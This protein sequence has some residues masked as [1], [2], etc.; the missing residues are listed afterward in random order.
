[1]ALPLDLLRQIQDSNPAAAWEAIV[2]HAWATFCDPVNDANAVSD[3]VKRD[4]GIADVDLFLATARWDLWR[5][6]PAVAKTTANALAEWWEARDGGRAVLI[7][8]GLSLREVPWLLGGLHS[9]GYVVHQAGGTGAELPPNTTPFAKALGFASRSTLY[10]NGAG[11]S[12]RL[13]G[14]RTECL[15]VAWEDAAA[16][17][18]SE[19]RW[20]LW[21][22]WPDTRIHELAEHGKGLSELVAE[23]RQAMA[24]DGFWTLIERLTQSRRLVITGDHGYAASGLFPDMT[25]P[26]QVR[27]MKDCFKA[28]RSASDDGAESPWVPPVDLVLDT[29]H[30]RHRYVLG[31]RKWR[32]SGGHPTLSHGGLS[33]LEVLVPFIDVSRVAG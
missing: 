14:A 6:W 29:D 33:V 21:H 2:E 4:K 30:G 1:M 3:I 22:E 23:V 5:Q 24:S 20:V 32:V 15:K 18:T 19:P 8:D 28:G 17:I 9:R 10:N 11:N 16:I 26:D 13:P 7:L 12:H 25:D 31:R 27:H